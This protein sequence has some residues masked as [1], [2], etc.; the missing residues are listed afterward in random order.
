[1]STA[2]LELDLAPYFLATRIIV[3]ERND[4]AVTADPGIHPVVMLPLMLDVNG[5]DERLTLEAE[6]RLE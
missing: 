6:F 4:G 5:F 1:M 2:E 3:T